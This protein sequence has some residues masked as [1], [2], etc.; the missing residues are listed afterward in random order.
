M[1][2]WNRTWEILSYEN[3]PPCI[4]THSHPHMAAA[5]QCKTLRFMFQCVWQL[6]WLCPMCGR[7]PSSCP[8]TLR[9]FHC[10][11]GASCCENK[12]WLHPHCWLSLNCVCVCV[13]IWSVHM[14]KNAHPLFSIPLRSSPVA[15]YILSPDT[16]FPRRLWQSVIL[17]LLTP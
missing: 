5:G 2:D 4:Q 7:T 6:M 3:T 11:R 14:F 13:F 9:D 15:V 12:R 1:G 16:L 17:V 10:H 8:D